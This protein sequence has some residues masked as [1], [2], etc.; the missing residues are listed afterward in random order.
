MLFWIGN[1][2]CLTH[3]LAKTSV[4]N[5]DYATDGTVCEW[6]FDRV[7]V[8]SYGTRGKKKGNQRF[9]QDFL[10]GAVMKWIKRKI[11]GLPGRISPTD[12]ESISLVCRIFI[13]SRYSFNERK[14]GADLDQ[15]FVGATR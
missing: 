11:S 10:E 14:P 3:F 9:D 7:S 2:E 8:T 5:N 1:V 4:A 6:L 15:L 13:H 12:S